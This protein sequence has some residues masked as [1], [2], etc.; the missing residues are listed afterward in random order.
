MVLHGNRLEDLRDLLTQV[1][2]NMPLGPLEPEVILLQSNGMKH[3]LELALADDAALGICAATR[4]ELPGSYLWQMYRAVLGA[5]AVPEHMPFDKAALLWRLVRLLPALCQ[6]NPV[7]VPL[8]RYLSGDNPARKLYQLAEQL[9]DVLDGYQS[10]RADWL[11]DWADGRDQLRGP[12][13]APQPLPSE[14]AWQAQLW[15]DIRADVGPALMDAS[16]ASVH[17]RFMAALAQLND[18]GNM[19]HP[20]GL[21]RRLIVFGISSLSTQ[22]VQ[23]LAALGQVCQVMLLVQNPCQYFWG[24]VVEGHAALRAQVRRRQQGKPLASANGVLPAAT[25]QPLLASWGKQ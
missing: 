13:G 23:A 2:H 19:S 5:D 11:A 6:A 24:D 25:A 18:S 3:W 15:R 1:L 9:A 17:E 10:Y 22:A 4:M 7:Y 8:K 21:P 20:S 14:H 16:R 12:Q